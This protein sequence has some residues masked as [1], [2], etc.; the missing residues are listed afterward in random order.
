MSFG[1]VDDIAVRSIGIQTVYNIIEVVEK[2][3]KERDMKLNKKKC[4]IVPLC[5][6]LVIKENEHIAKIEVVN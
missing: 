4:Q 2:F 1:F 6:R 5:K 3:F